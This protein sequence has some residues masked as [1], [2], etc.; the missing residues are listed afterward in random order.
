M[1]IAS[2]IQAEIVNLRQRRD[3]ITQ[4]AKD[5]VEKIN[6]TISRLIAAATAVQD[7]AAIDAFKVLKE[8]GLV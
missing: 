3:E 8:R 2:D 1:S 4:A 6:L 5:E 7:P